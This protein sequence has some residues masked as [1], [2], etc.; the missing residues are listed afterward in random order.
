[1]LYRSSLTMP[2][3]YVAA[4]RM[5]EEKHPTIWWTPYAAHCLDLVPEHIDKIEWVKKCVEHEKSITKYIYNHSWV[6][7]LMRKNTGGKELVRSTI[8]RF[9]TNFLSLQSIV[10]KKANLRKMFSCDEWNESQWSKRDEGKEVADKVFEKTFWKKVEEIVLF[11]E[12]LVK[13]L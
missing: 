12:P 3:N 11:S 13:V 4:G 7:S 9:A 1:M 5:L 2:Q 8:T 6:L 10:D